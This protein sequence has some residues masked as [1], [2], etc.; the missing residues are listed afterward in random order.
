MES[1]MT[2][3]RGDAGVSDGVGVKGW[4]PPQTERSAKA[5]LRSCPSWQE[6]RL[7]ADWGEEQPQ[8]GRASAEALSQE[9]ASSN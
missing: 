7:W 8:K 5:S 6:A 2:V 9:R 4:R 3:R 1:V